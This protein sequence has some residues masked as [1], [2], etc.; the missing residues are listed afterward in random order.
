MLQVETCNLKQFC[1]TLRS[2]ENR[3]AICLMQV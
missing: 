2:F 3:L 1:P